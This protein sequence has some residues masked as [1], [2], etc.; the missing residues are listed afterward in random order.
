MFCKSC[1]QQNDDANRFCEYCGASLV[2]Q[3]VQQAAAWRQQPAMAPN[4]FPPVKTKTTPV[5]VYILIT[6]GVVAILLAL[7]FGIRF[8]LKIYNDRQAEKSQMEWQQIEESARLEREV[9]QRQQQR[10]QQQAQDESDLFLSRIA[11]QMVSVQGGAF[12]MGCTAEQGSDCYDGESPAHRVSL[13]SFSIGKYPVTQKQWR[14]VMGTNPSRFAGCDNCPVENVSWHDAQTF[15][16]RLNEKSGQKYRL[17]TEAEWEYAARGGNMSRGYRFSGSNTISS[18][19]WY[20]SNSAKSTH[21]VGDKQPN[22]LG[23]YDMSGNVWEWCEDWHGAYSSNAQTNPKGPS[24]GT[25]RIA[26]GGCWFNLARTC[27]VSNRYSSDPNAKERFLGFRV[28]QS[29]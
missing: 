21:A 24:S 12:I 11:M 14:E 4:P 18:V 19:A 8:G 15:I 26:R 2:Q 9:E 27:R 25:G 13:S 5:W 23:I 7:F 6:A 17:P 28:A 3:V 16:N 1:G 22:E 20:D 29:H 10:R